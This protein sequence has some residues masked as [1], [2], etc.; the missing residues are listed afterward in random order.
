MAT[1][2]AALRAMR[3]LLSQRGIVFWSEPVGSNEPLQNRNP[4][5]KLRANIS[6][7]HCLTVSLAQE[8]AGLGTIIGEVGARQLAHQAA[9]S[10][11]E[12]LPIQSAAQQFFL[13]RSAS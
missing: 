8:G 5:G 11:F 1:P 6:P 3:L 12:R 13:L 4:Q 10:H 7:F 9:F 2:V